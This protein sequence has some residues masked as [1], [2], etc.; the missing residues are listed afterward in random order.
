M[1][2]GDLG[3]SGGYE[4]RVGLVGDPSD[5]KILGVV[6]VVQVVEVLRPKLLVGTL[7]RGGGVV[8]RRR[9]G[10]HVSSQRWTVAGMKGWETEVERRGSTR[11]GERW[12][13]GRDR[14]E[15][16]ERRGRGMRVGVDK[17]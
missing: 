16:R 11:V 10:C 7:K 17:R 8:M 14:W 4:L 13:R 6:V 5:D 2:G 15:R 12:E 1:K 3:L 9:T